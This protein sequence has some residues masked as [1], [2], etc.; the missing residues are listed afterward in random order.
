MAD[1][2]Q[3]FP[4][5]APASR[6]FEA[7][8]SPQGLDSWWTR[9]SSGEPHLG[10]QYRLGF[11]P[12]YDWRGRVTQ[13]DKNSAFELQITQAGPDWNGTRVGFHLEESGG[14]T[15]VRFHHTG[16][17]SQNEHWRISCY[18]WA[19]YLRVLRRYVEHGEFVAYEK[20]LDV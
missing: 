4:I 2:F 20:R 17:P 18:C 1:I 16:W 11:G 9:E 10:S 3:D 5:K 12:K 6:V 13:C 19:M 7:V 8:S 15:N 14:T